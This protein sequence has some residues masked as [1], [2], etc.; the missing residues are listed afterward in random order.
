MILHHRNREPGVMFE[1]QTFTI[2]PMLTMGSTK[3][4]RAVVWSRGF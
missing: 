1:G 4:R 2:E 3:V